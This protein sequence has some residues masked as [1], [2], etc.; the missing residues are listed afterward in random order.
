M[1]YVTFRDCKMEKTHQKTKIIFYFN[2]RI[3]PT[4]VTES[5]MSVIGKY[6]FLKTL[7]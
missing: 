5:Q 6:V 7:T 3:C 2:Q 1:I 4:N